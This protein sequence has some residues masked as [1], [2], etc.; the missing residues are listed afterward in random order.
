MNHQACWELGPLEPA[1]V[2]FL[3]IIAIRPKTNNSNNNNNNS[4]G[5]PNPKP[6]GLGLHVFRSPAPERRAS[7][8]FPD[9]IIG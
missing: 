3:T 7:R 9:V 2:F 1:C 5:H 6:K 4:P 8:L